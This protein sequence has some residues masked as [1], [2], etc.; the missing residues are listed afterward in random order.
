MK[1]KSRL[2]ET[3]YSRLLVHMQLLLCLRRQ[4]GGYYRMTVRQHRVNC[5]HAHLKE[6][7]E[8]S[9][10]LAEIERPSLI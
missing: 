9:E 10:A 3:M 5:S 7:P 2:V 1:I 8:R 6:S 4:R